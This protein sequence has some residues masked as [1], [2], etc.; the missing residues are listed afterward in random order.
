MSDARDPH[1]VLEAVRRLESELAG[2]RARALHPLAGEID[3]LRET[4]AEDAATERRRMVE[5]LDTVLAL[6]GDSW[7]N[8]RAQLDAMRQELA[9]TRAELSALR[10]AMK[11]ATVEVRFAGAGHRAN[12]ASPPARPTWPA[13]ASG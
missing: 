10:A 2:V 3:R 8:T 11:G 6:V 4:L 13:T 1:E 9:A 12:G 7:R 5:D